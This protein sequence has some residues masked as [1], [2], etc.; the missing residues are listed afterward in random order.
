MTVIMA[1]FEIRNLK[2][3]IDNLGQIFGIH[4]K[5]RERGL[6][7]LP[8]DCQILRVMLRGAVCC[9]E[10]RSQNWEKRLAASPRL[11][12]RPHGTTRR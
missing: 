5:C 2:G 4:D 11:S 12:V 7:V 10:A 1:V 3:F 6:S 9:F 8:Q